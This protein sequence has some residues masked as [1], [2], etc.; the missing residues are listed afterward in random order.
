[1]AE[2][3]TNFGSDY[4]IRNLE[5]LSSQY[6]G[7]VEQVP[8][9]LNNPPPGLLRGRDTPGSVFSGVELVDVPPF[10]GYG[11]EGSFFEDFEANNN[12]SWFSIEIIEE[13]IDFSAPDSSLTETFNDDWTVAI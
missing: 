9:S 2:K 11:S 10:T 3:K 12:T 4:T 13:P 5:V 7:T 8:M 1:M 6:S